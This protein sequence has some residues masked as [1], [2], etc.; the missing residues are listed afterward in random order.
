MVPAVTFTQPALAS[1]GLSESEAK[2]HGLSAQTAVLPLEAVPRALANRDTGRL[3]GAQVVADNAEEVI[4]AAILEVE[5]GLAIADV[6]DTLAPY[7][8]MAEG[9]KLAALTFDKEVSKLSCCAG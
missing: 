3:R 4:D 7:F 9:L 1:V 8:T 6:T 2:R 5:H